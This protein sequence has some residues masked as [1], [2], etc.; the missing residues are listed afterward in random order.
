MILQ[1]FVGVI[2]RCGCRKFGVCFLRGVSCKNVN[3]IIP[4]ELFAVIERKFRLPGVCPFVSDGSVS[5]QQQPDCGGR[6]RVIILYGAVQIRAD[7]EFR[8][9]RRHDCVSS[10]EITE[11]VGILCLRSSLQQVGNRIDRMGSEMEITFR[12]RIAVIIRT[13]G[14]VNRHYR[15][16]TH[17]IIERVGN[18]SV[19][20]MAVQIGEAVLP[21]TADGQIH[22]DIQIFVEFPFEIDARRQPVEI[23]IAYDTVL[24]GIVSRYKEPRFLVSA[25]EGDLMISG[26]SCPERLV[27]PVILAVCIAG[28]K[29]FT[30]P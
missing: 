13:V 14:I 30:F 2:G 25:A 17:G 11:R 10:D 18:T 28:V 22:G 26:K 3:V 7:I 27:A 6:R 4:V 23:G 1:R 12:K 24:F 19:G 8:N 16:Y 29:G 15:R 9:Q 5:V 21:R 20:I